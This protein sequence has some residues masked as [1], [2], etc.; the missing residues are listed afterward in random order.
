MWNEVDVILKLYGFNGNFD[1]DRVMPG[2]L[3]CLYMKGA[4]PTWY[5]NP[6]TRL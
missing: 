4:G 3:A 2:A 1:V 6:A 5:E